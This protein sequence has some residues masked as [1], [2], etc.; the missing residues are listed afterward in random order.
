MCGESRALALGRQQFGVD[1]CGLVQA[2]DG[3][4]RNPSLMNFPAEGGL[5]LHKTAR[6]CAALKS[7][8]SRKHSYSHLPVAGKE[9]PCAV[10]ALA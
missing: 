2:V 7:V 10:P 3:E 9:L 4:S 6:G 1:L 8:L 5:S